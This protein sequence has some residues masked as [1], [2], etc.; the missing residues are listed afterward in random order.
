MTPLETARPIAKKTA[1]SSDCGSISAHPRK[2]DIRQHQYNLPRQ[3]SFF[4]RQ[5]E[6]TG[7]CVGHHAAGDEAQR[8]EHQHVAGGLAGEMQHLYQI[9]PAP[10]PLQCQIIPIPEKRDDPQQPEVAAAA[11]FPRLPTATMKP[12]TRPNSCLLNQWLKTVKV[13]ISTEAVPIPIS[14]RAAMATARVS[15]WEKSRP[16]DEITREMEEVGEELE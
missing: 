10:Q 13:A 3:Q 5:E 16:P 15:A 9:R 4:V 12:E 1:A 8:G 6:T 11:R 14:T 7:D 2:A